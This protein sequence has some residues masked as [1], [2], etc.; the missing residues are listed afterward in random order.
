MKHGK[1]VN[2]NS[3]VEIPVTLEAEFLGSFNFRIDG[4]EKSNAF[5]RSEWD[6]TPDTPAL[7]T[8]HGYYGIRFEDDQDAPNPFTRIFE[9]GEDGWVE[10]GALEAWDRDELKAFLEERQETWNLTRLVFER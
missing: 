8:K 3:G 5:A 6:F 9:L 4:S 1:I 7:P 2:K 10:R